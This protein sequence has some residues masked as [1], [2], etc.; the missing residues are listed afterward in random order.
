MEINRVEKTM[1]LNGG[2]MMALISVII[3]LV[4]VFYFYGY[5]CPEGFV[6][7]CGH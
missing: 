7:G 2:E 4:V 5:S 1:D 3:M 6:L